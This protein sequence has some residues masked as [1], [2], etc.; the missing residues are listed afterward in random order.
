MSPSLTQDT[1]AGHLLC[2]PT[3]LECVGI[4]TLMGPGHLGWGTG[5]GRILVASKECVL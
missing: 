2:T 3:F 5:L 4:T 1:A